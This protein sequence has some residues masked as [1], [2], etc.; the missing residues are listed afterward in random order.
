MSKGAA[1][2]AGGGGVMFWATPVGQAVAITIGA[3]V[4]GVVVYF[5]LVRPFT[6]ILGLTE[7]KEDKK[8][9]KTIEQ[10]E[11]QSY[12]SASYWRSAPNKLSHPEARYVSM[13]QDVND[14]L[15][16]V[17][18]GGTDEEKIYGVFRLLRTKEDVSKLSDVYVNTQNEDMYTAI[19]D[20]FST[21]EMATL[22]SIINNFIK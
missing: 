18:W 19:V 11:K 16:N 7:S 17:P 22:Q 2:M 5:G 20:D 12:W 1:N 10:G 8:D 13:A 3:S 6:N 21:S 4:L 15:W 9:A 14:A